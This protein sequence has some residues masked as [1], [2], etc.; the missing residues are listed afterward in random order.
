MSDILL[1]MS[2]KSAETIGQPLLKSHTYSR[3]D[4]KTDKTKTSTDDI[5]KKPTEWDMDSMGIVAFEENTIWHKILERNIANKLLKFTNLKIQWCIAGIIIIAYVVGAFMFG[6]YLGSNFAVIYMMCNTPVTF[7]FVIIYLF[8]VNIDIGK[9][10]IKYF[11]FWW[12]MVN[13]TIIEII[14]GIWAHFNVEFDELLTNNELNWF[15]MYGGIKITSI[16]GMLTICLLGAY[17]W[18]NKLKVC[19]PLLVGINYLHASYYWQCLEDSN[20]LISIK[21]DGYTKY[22]Y[23]DSLLTYA[24]INVAVFLFNQAWI[25]YRYPNKTTLMRSELQIIWLSHEYN[26]KGLKAGDHVIINT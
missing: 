22:I 4:D 25:A 14:S 16:L 19:M 11:T 17:K 3:F 6:S 24:N 8:T 10:L 2:I 26:N 15:V 21:I 20:T 23:I 13:I 9:D 7:I 5:T 18:N 1:S 12:K